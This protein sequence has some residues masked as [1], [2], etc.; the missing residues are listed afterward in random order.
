MKNL[1]TKELFLCLPIEKGMQERNFLI[2]PLYILITLVLAGIT[3]LFLGFSAAYLYN[4]FQEGAQAV[5]LPSLFYINTLILMASGGTLMLAKRA[6]KEDNT[7]RYQLMLLFSTILTIVFLIAQIVAWNQMRMMNLTLGS[8]N[9]TSY[10]YVISALH[11]LHV[12]AGIPFLVLFL[13]SAKVN[14]KE[15]VS[16][17]VYFSDPDKKRKLEVLTIYWHYLDALWIYLILFF[18]VNYLIKI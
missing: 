17:L 14:M 18:L 3:A 16:V 9:M 12:V 11:F 6:Y 8:D 15:P 1:Q 13:Y 7:E 5:Q 4:R 2:H 10:I